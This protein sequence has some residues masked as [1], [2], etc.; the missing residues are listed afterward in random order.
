MIYKPNQKVKQK[1]TKIVETKK[2]PIKKI[3]K[4]EQ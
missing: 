1:N 3:L 4:K 2:F